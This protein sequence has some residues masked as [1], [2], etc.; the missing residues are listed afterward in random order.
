MKPIMIELKDAS[1]SSEV[2][3]SR[4]HPFF[5]IF[6]YLLLAIL[7][8]A[9]LW[10][11]FYRIEIVVKEAG[12]AK[13]EEDT[14]RVMNETGG[15]L[16]E[17]S[18]ADGDVVNEG[19]VL[20][21]LDTADAETTLAA[22][23][24]QLDSLNDRIA[25]ITAYQAALGGSTEDMDALD[26][27]PYYAEYKARLDLVEQNCRITETTADGQRAQY[28]QSVESCDNSAAYN[29]DKLSELQLMLE[30]INDRQNY[31]D[32]NDMY[33]YNAAETY[34]VS[35]RTTGQK[36]DEEIEAAAASKASL[37][38]IQEFKNRKSSALQALET[39]NITSWQQQITAVNE[40]LASLENSRAEA[41]ARLDT[42][43]DDAVSQ[44]V[45]AA[46][47]TELNTVYAER[48]T[49]ISRRTE[50]ETNIQ[51]LKDSIGKGVVKAG[52]SGI[53]NLQTDLAAGNYLPAGTEVM[54][55]VPD[56]RNGYYVEAY[57][58][59]RDIGKLK[60]G[61]KVR[62]EVGAY[63]AEEYGMFT[64]TLE[65]ISED[66]KGTAGT[67]S[68]TYYMAQVKLDSPVLQNKK[69]ET[70][71][72]KQGMACSIRIVTGEKSVWLYLL[73]KIDLWDSWFCY[74]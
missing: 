47:L 53:I 16:K 54:D 26:T 39:E 1:E 21:M 35:Y 17:V 38:T 43:G 27:D 63:P 32:R 5:R 40:T 15:V 64:G 12:I 61:M 45:N 50:L 42:V 60:N 10:A 33:Y 72:L 23:Q 4:P 30:C 31:F 14:I 66:V 56:G 20:Y 62:C 57:I 52:K 49:Y 22:Q 25:V 19:D 36:Y 65:G 58:S 7:V 13:L 2:Y 9:F 46:K 11:Y 71:V 67:D 6:I 41:A 8:T 37:S 69:G 48:N 51:T 70:A 74:F 44:N 29:S 24:K 28:R 73:E 34:L 68:E 55:I 18:A 3:D 59:N